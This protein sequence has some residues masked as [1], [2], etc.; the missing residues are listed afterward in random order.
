VLVIDA[1]F[2][3]EYAGGHI[4]NAI[5]FRS[6]AEME[7]VYSHFREC[8][9]AVVFYCEFSHTRGRTLM[10]AFREYDRM[11][12]IDQYPEL[13]YPRIFLL[14]GGYQRFYAELP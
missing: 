9:F 2:E 4:N 8:N 1:R 13:S 7:N 5:N 12:H 11:V 14:K 6:R 10:T 3:Y